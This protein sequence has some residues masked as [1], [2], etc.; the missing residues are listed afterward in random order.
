MNLFQPGVFQP[1]VGPKVSGPSACAGTCRPRHGEKG[2]R[3]TR[4]LSLLV[5]AG[6]ILA[7]ATPAAAS[8]RYDPKTKTGFVDSADVRHAFGWTDTTLSSRASGLV[9]HHDFWTDDTYSVSCGGHAFPVV[10]HRDYGW[11]ELSVTVTR[12]GYRTGVTGFRLTGP[13]LGISGTSAPP[14][15]GQPCPE[16][17]GQAPG[18]AIDEVHLRGSATGW[19][20]SAAFQD[21]SRVLQTSRRR[22]LR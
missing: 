15:P 11:F 14:E 5:V 8:V 17:Q 13:H 7:L 10:H 9:F 2:S 20:L 21:A 22:R 18:A 19:A 16:P 4:P 6:V 3:S 12:D 1:D